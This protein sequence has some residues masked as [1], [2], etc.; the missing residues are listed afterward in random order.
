MLLLMVFLGG[1]S[2]LLPVESAHSCYYFVNDV[3]KC[4][5]GH[6]DP[7]VAKCIACANAAKAAEP[8]GWTMCTDKLISDACHGIMPNAPVS[9]GQVD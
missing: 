3:V 2:R 4:S 8:K 1:S 7:D 9:A 6:S 5:H